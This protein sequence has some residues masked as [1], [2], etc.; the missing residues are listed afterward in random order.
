MES[1]KKVIKFI[2]IGLL[3]EI[4]LSA[5]TFGMTELFGLFGS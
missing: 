1:I 5:L 3:N 2:I 4:I